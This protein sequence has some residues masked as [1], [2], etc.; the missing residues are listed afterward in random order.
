M[1]RTVMVV[2]VGVV[3][4][5]LFGCSV[6]DPSPVNSLVAVEVGGDVV[7]TWSNPPQR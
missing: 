1:N 4:S 3:I 7:L 6:F 2:L 5:W